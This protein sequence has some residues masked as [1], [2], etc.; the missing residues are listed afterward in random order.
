MEEA[1]FLAKFASKVTIVHRRDEFRA[2][3]IMLDRAREAENI[4]FLTPYVVDEFVAGRRR[5]ARATA[6]LRNTETRRA[7]ASST[8]AGAFIAIGHEPA[9]GDRRRPGRDSTT[10]GYIVTEGKSTQTNR[11]GV[12]AAGDLVDHTYRQAVTAAG[13]GLPGRARRRV[14]P[15]RHARGPDARGDAR[16]RPGRGAV[17][18]GEAVGPPAQR[19]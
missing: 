6:E 3:Q 10:S 15:A 7:S 14:V 8:I 18:P 1:I 16:G 17:G 9:V 12:F 5:R 2:S 19:R 13:S 11:P 4:E